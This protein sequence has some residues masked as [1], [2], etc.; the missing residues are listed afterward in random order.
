MRQE[1]RRVDP[2]RTANV[3]ALVYG[4]LMS[5]FALMFFPFFLLV[6]ILAPSEELGRAGPLFAV[7]LLLF[8]PVMGFVM[9]WISGLLASVI[10]NF[11]IRWS[12]GLLLEFDSVRLPTDA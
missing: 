2:L 6:G 3:G 9:G 4:L 5:A 8:Y 11:V 7:L 12:G 1:L 10:Y